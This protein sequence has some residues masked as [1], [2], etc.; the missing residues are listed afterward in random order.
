M[1]KTDIPYY[2]DYCIELAK[3][4]ISNID[5]E[6]SEGILNNTL[7]NNLKKRCPEMTDRDFNIADTVYG[8]I[9]RMSNDEKTN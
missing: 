6:L 4:K 9:E 1:Y 5:L 7:K 8:I 3:L 2:T